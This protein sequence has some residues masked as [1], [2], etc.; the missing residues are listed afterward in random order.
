[1][2][3]AA[4]VPGSLAEDIIRPL[5]VP[6]LIP[7]A[8]GPLGVVVVQEDWVADSR[9]QAALSQSLWYDAIFN[10][11]DTW[12]ETDKQFEYV[13]VGATKYTRAGS[14]VGVRVGVRARVSTC[15]RA[16][17]GAALIT[18]R[19]Q[20]TVYSV[21]DGPYQSQRKTDQFRNS[22]M[23]GR[24]C[25]PQRCLCCVP[26]H[27]CCCSSSCH[28]SM[29]SADGRI[30]VRVWGCP[31]IDWL[32]SAVSCPLTDVGDPPAP[33]RGCLY[34]GLVLRWTTNSHCVVPNRRPTA[35]GRC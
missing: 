30:A 29:P 35:D 15:A 7:S 17:I 2:G 8:P 12:C 16:C 10:L 6:R 13:T 28:M 27:C 26:C 34:D 19:R 22:G 9:G 33:N 23:G 25:C 11:A 31:A 14:C 18:G 20:C 1:M 3:S 5:F 24:C 21:P 4:V 32:P